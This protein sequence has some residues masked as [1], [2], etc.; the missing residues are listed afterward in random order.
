MGLRLVR[1]TVGIR[2]AKRAD[3]SSSD[4]TRLSPQ[5]PRMGPVMILDSVLSPLSLLT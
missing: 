3:P 2:G 5:L 1:R 4:V